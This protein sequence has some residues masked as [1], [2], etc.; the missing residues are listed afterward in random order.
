MSTNPTKNKN[1]HNY[2]IT[3]GA[4][5]LGLHVTKAL[6]KNKNSV[7]IL[8]IADQPSD[9]VYQKTKYIQGDVRNKK[10]VKQAIKDIDVVIHAAAALPLST[11]REITTTTVNGTQTVLDAFSK[12]KKKSNKH[13]I[14][15]SST[16][17]YGVPIKHPIEETDPLIGVGPY[18]HAKIKAEKICQK[19]RTPNLNVSIIRPKTFIGTERLGV[20]QILCNWV[21][22]GHRIPIIGNGKNRYQLMDVEDIVNAILLL[23]S[24]TQNT[25]KLSK[26][27]RKL[28]NTEFNVGAEKFTTVAQDVGALCE[29]AGNHSRVFPIPSW[30]V[31]PILRGLEAVNLS[32]LYKW[33][34]DT[35]DKDSF[36]SIE[37]IKAL[38][39]KPKY[40]NAQALIRMYDWYLKNYQQYEARPS[41]TTHRVGWNQG[42]LGLIKK[43]L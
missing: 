30:L 41:G 4:G 34:Y 31:K 13:F 12:T 2:L 39:W 20:F 40:S 18:G 42:A 33:V 23:A 9:R 11:P 15:I 24:F 16:A 25:Q 8:D 36:V 32:P 5:F 22:E 27:N 29:H 28:I 1:P 19:Y 17:V 3:G 35:A 21:R 10:D 7:T 26:T 6:V 37:K 43:F 38:G 14:Y